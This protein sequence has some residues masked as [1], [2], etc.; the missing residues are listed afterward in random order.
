MLAYLKTM[1]GHLQAQLLPSTCV[2]C[3]ALSGREIDLCCGCEADL[4][5]L[6]A[7]C[8][9]CAL[10]LTNIAKNQPVVCGR[11]LQEKPVF[12]ATTAL[13]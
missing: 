13:F 4:P 8:F 5:W 1:L 11:C 3:S 6:N 2:L 7:V 9:Q 12:F 10:P